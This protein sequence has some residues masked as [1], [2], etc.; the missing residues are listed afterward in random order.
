MRR[1]RTDSHRRD[2][3]MVHARLPR[4]AAKVAPSCVLLS[5]ARTVMALSYVNREHSPTHAAPQRAS[6]RREACACDRV[7]RTCI[8]PHTTDGRM[9]TSELQPIACVTRGAQLSV[10]PH[11]ATHARKGGEHG[12][13]ARKKCN[14]NS[15]VCSTSTCAVG[16]AAALLSE[17][18]ETDNR[19]LEELLLSADLI[20]Q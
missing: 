10:P 2:L 1:P 5:R 15:T 20:I 7:S 3:C 16:P 17:S 14:C 19:T 18:D 13:G 4:A 9:C 6:R 8:P 12:V 11:D